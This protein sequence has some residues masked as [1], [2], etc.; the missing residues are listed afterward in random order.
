M[1]PKLGA[2]DHAA[3]CGRQG[4][5]FDPVHLRGL[6]RFSFHRRAPNSPF[7]HPKSVLACQIEPLEPPNRHFPNPRIAASA[8]S[9]RWV[10][11]TRS[12]A[13]HLILPVAPQLALRRRFLSSSR[14]SLS[15]SG[16]RLFL[17]CLRSFLPHTR[18]KHFDPTTTSSS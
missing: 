7:P 13:P 4:R 5:R 6:P 17:S 1:N 14:R 16:G 12:P 9:R 15:P 18:T 11:T 8:A 3:R 10:S 2:F